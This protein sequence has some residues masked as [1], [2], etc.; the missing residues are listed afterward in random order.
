VE[1]RSSTP[2]SWPVPSSTVRESSPTAFD[3][4]ASVNGAITVTA[5]VAGSIVTSSSTPVVVP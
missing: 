5:A 4:P 2:K 3:E 1:P